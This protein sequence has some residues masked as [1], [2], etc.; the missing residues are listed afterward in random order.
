VKGGPYTEGVAAR[1]GQYGLVDIA[2]HGST[3]GV[4]LTGRTWDGQQPVAATFAV[5]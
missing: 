2:D 4:T 5:P 1:P 3:I